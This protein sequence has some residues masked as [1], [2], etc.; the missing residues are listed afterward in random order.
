MRVTV[1]RHAAPHV[2]DD[3]PPHVWPLSPSGRAAARGLRLPEG[4]RAVAS[5]ERKA[6]ETLSLALGVA[7]VPTDPRFGEIRRPPEPV[8]PEFR[9]ARRAWVEGAPDTRHDGWESAEGAARRFDDAVRDHAGRGDL[10]VGTHG[11]V[12]TAWL[13]ATGRVAPGPSA[14]AFWLGLRL[15]DVVTVDLAGDDDG[16]PRGCAGPRRAKAAGLRRRPRPR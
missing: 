14:G 2:T 16:D 10:V 5:D 11:M 1:V 4:A 6:V 9:E 3:V 13:V 15:P 12:L 8:S 7:D